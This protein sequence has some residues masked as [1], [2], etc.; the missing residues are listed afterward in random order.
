LASQKSLDVF[1]EPNLRLTQALGLLGYNAGYS[2][3]PGH[4]SFDQHQQDL[5]WRLLGDAP[6]DA[7]AKVV[8]VGCGIGGPSSWIFDR[9]KPRLLV[10]VEYC[11]SSV[12]EAESR[13]AGQ[14]IRPVFVQGDAHH[15]P[16]ADNSVDVIFNLESALHY[17]DKRAFIREC[18]RV[19]K[20]GG[21][22][23]LGDITTTHKVLFTLARLVNVINTQYSTHAKLWSCRDYLQCF[24]E[25]GLKLLRHEDV[26]QQAACS[27][28]DGLAPLFRNGMNKNSDYRGRLLYLALMERLLRR[29]WMSY[30]LFC[31]SKPAA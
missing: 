13:W 11:P 21:M 26:A 8:D 15:L 28:E 1:Y 14:R 2:P 31:V 9:Y 17:A 6:I 27:L 3:H 4:G 24:A 20:P 25:S 5:V 12:R 16:L 7:R 23:C 22:L 18:R 19:L 29:G 10:G 30:D